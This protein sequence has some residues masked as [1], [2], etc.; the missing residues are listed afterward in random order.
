MKLDLP[1]VPQCVPA[2]E[3]QAWNEQQ[4]AT[5]VMEPQVRLWSYRQAAVVLGCAQRQALDG[6]PGG[7]ASGMETI[8]RQAG[9]GAVLVGPWMLSA[10]IALPHGHP[11]VTASPVSSYR[12]LGEL[13]AGVLRNVGLA[14]HAVTPDEARDFHHAHDLGKSL[15][16]AC[17][18]GISPWEVVV[19]QRKIVGLAQIR[20]RTGIL[21]VAGLLLERPEWPALC[22]A[23]NRPAT[24]VYHL[25]QRTTSCADEIGVAPSILEIAHPLAWALDA[26]IRGPAQPALRHERQ[27]LFFPPTKET[28]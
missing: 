28:V 19:G 3:E 4:L 12:W 25:A 27:A 5:P 13:Y 2:H 7:A 20:R 18:G 10:S 22:Q 24:H 6:L 8:V 14:A 16:W 23:M 21:L 17:Y 1:H 11:L 15:D 9:G 26:A